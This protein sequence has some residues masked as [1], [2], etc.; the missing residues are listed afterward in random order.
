MSIA[1]YNSIRYARAMSS[2]DA[3]PGYLLS[4]ARSATLAALNARLR[5]TGLKHVDVSMLLLID[6]TPGITQSEA[7]RTLD[8]QRANMTPLAAR[9]EKSGWISRKPVDG[10]SHGMVLTAQG[11]AKVDQAR[12][13]IGAFETDLLASVDAQQRDHVVPVLRALWRGAATLV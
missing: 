10:R 7:G 4:R 11:Q 12:A 9:L 1:I 5:D 3:L 8:I 6:E 13:I 2:L